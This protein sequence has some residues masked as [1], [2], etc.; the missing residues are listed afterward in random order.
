MSENYMSTDGFKPLPLPAKGTDLQQGRQYYLDPVARAA[1]KDMYGLAGCPA[2]ITCILA[3]R[4]KTMVESKTTNL[5]TGEIIV[6]EPLVLDAQ[7]ATFL[8]FIK[9]RKHEKFTLDLEEIQLRRPFYVEAHKVS[10]K[11]PKAKVESGAPRVQKKFDL[12]IL[13][14]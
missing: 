14:L 6:S 10:D 13:D 5:E 9:F 11:E 12:S 1:L 4:P 8:A 7:D 2:I 3:K